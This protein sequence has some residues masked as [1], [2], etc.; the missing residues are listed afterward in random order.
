[1]TSSTSVIKSRDQKQADSWSPSELDFLPEQ[2]PEVL[3]EEQPV[4][5]EKNTAGP[6][7]EIIQAE[8]EAEKILA[9]ARKEAETIRE[10][11][12][13]KGL[14]EGRSGVEQDILDAAAAAK[15][16]VEQAAS[17]QQD[18]LTTGEEQIVSMISLT[19]EKLFGKG[20]ELDEASLRNL[21]MEVF[22]RA[23]TLG[24]LR[25]F[26]NPRDADLLTKEWLQK[27]NAFHGVSIMLIPDETIQPGGCL[28]EGIYGSVDARIENRLE[29]VLQALKETHAETRGGSQ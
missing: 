21:M 22:Q 19:A 12:R 10:E 24:D 4:E 18:F 9:S 17:W 15:S 5:I 14:Q 2:S 20:Y 8:I 23:R 3:E 26:L 7:E 28:V 1:M 25:C 6:T 16:L 13:Q 29:T 11:A 27:Q